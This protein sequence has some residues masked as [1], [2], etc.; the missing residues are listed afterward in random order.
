MRIAFY[1]PMKAPGD[2]VASGER[3]LA[4]LFL[5]AL[6]AGGMEVACG[7]SF[8]SYDRGEPVRQARL[9]AAGGRLAGRFLDR[10]RQGAPAPDLW[11]TYHL[12]HKA[13]DHIGPCV[14]AALKIPYVVAEASYAPKQA[15]GPWRQGLAASRR[16]IGAAQRIYALNPADVACLRPI[17]R[18]AGV[19]AE[20]SP[21]IDVAPYRRAAS[22]RTAA[23]AALAARFGLDAAKPLLLTVAMMRDDQKLSSYGVLGD[24][25]SR[26]ESADWQ[27]LVVGAGPA[28]ARVR[29]LL[30][31]LSGAVAFAGALPAAEMP[32]IFA[33][34][35]LFVWPA[36]KEAL[37]MVILEAAAAGAAVV[38]GR[39]GAAGRMVEDGATGILVPAGDAAAI[40]AA[41]DR[42]LDEPGRIRAMGRA[43]AARA[44]RVNDIAAASAWLSTDL[45]QIAKHHR[46]EPVS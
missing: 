11:F 44:L 39:S 5:A 21:F 4:R 6:E 12:Y 18:D 9:E 22:D 33:G 23:K 43:A 38:A 40:A 36:V 26:L 42:L 20:L 34:A 37:G 16:A 8:R 25:L 35:D 27:L 19:I 17:V 1:A 46:L 45:R 15:R 14:S 32:A 2:P 24:S 41:L 28:E 3:T 7:S 29:A 31:G 10:I 13:P 30:G